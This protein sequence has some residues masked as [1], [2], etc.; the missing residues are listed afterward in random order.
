MDS[1]KKIKDGSLAVIALERINII[2]KHGR[3][4]GID[5]IGPDLERIISGAPAPEEHPQ[6]GAQILF[7]DEKI[8]ITPDNREISYFHYVIRILNERGKENFSETHAEYDS[9]YEKVELEVAPY[10][11]HKTRGV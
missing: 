11:T 8:E 6:A 7:C 4:I 9:T 5:R 10:A 3:D 1:Y 2:E